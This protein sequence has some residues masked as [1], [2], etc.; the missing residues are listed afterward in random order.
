MGMHGASPRG[1]S[2]SGE[3]IWSGSICKIGV[4]RG[5]DVVL[6]CEVSRN[7]CLTDGLQDMDG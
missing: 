1:A 3:L 6:V 2:M 4:L 5:R 7:V